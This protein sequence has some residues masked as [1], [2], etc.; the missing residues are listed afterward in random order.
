MP[1]LFL[2]LV[3]FAKN[4]ADFAGEYVNQHSLYITSEDRTVHNIQDIVKIQAV[5]DNKANVLVETYTQNFQSCQLIGEAQLQG[6]SL[7]FT[8]AIDK[9]LNR[10]KAARCILKISAAKTDSGEKSVKVEDSGDNCRIRYCGLNA[11]LGGEFKE[12]TVSVQDK[13]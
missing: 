13:N 2:P 12:K 1:F 6:D 11:E 5:N 9:R 7:V 8:S 4:T 3:A 10:G